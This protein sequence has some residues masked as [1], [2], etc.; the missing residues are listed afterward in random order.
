MKITIEENTFEIGFNIRPYAISFLK[1]M[2]K[3]WEIIVFTAS[4]QSYAD[5]IL[6]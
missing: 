2:K 5:T 1:K 6:D 4:H 3:R